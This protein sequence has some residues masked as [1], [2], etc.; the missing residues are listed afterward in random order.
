MNIP[1]RL[2]ELLASNDELHGSI[3][4]TLHDFQIWFEDRNLPFFPEYTDHGPKHIEEV[5]ATADG[6]VTDESWTLLT[7]EDAAVLI[8]SIVLHDCAMHLSED[9]FIAL[10]RPDTPRMLLEKDKPWPELWSDFLGEA[11]RFDSRKLRS[12]FGDTEPTHPPSLD[13]RNMSLRDRLLIGDFLRRHHPRLAHEIALWGVPGPSSDRIGLVRVPRGLDNLAGLSARSHGS[14]LRSSVE[15]LPPLSR[16]EYHKVHVPYLMAVLR[17]ADYIQIHSER[18]PKQVLKVRSLKSPFSQG[19]WNAHEAVED[20]HCTHEDPEAL[21]VVAKPQDVKTFLKLERLLEGLQAELDS[22]WAT[23]GEVYGRW[24]DLQRLGLTIRR[25]RS[26]LDDK[27]AFALTVPYYPDRVAFEADPEILKLLIDPLYGEDP[28]IGIRELLQNAVDACVDL[29]DYQAQLSTED[30]TIRSSSDPAVIIHLEET[31]DGGGWLTVTDSGIGMTAEVV[32]NYFLKAGA[33]FRRS[34]AWKELHETAEGKSRVL[35]SGRFGIGLLSAF[36]LGDKLNVSTRHVTAPEANG[37]QFCCSIEDEQ[38]EIMRAKLSAV[39]TSIRIRLA[40]DIFVKLYQ[41][42][43][44]WEW[45]H[46]ENPAVER[47]VTELDDGEVVGSI[48]P[49]TFSIPGAHE[50]LPKDW[51]RIRHRDFEDI[52]WTYEIRSRGY[53]DWN[54]DGILFCNGIEI[55]DLGSYRHENVSIVKWPLSLRKPLLSV[56]DPDGR[57]PLNLTR[58]TLTR[59]LP[60]EEELV[61][62]ICRDLIAKLLVTMPDSSVLDRRNRLSYEQISYPGAGA[63]PWGRQ[64]RDWFWLTHKGLSLATRFLL[65]EQRPETLYLIPNRTSFH[66]EVPPQGGLYISDLDST[67]GDFDPWLRFVLSGK[68]AG[69]WYT[70][71][72]WLNNL[73]SV[74]RRVLLNKK[75]RNRLTNPRIIP[76]GVWSTLVDEWHDKDWAILSTE[77]CPKATTDFKLLAS[78][79]KPDQFTA[80][81]EWYFESIPDDG[82]DLIVDRV[83]KELIDLPFIPFEDRRTVLANTFDKLTDHLASH[84]PVTKKKFKARVKK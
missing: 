28:A 79:L 11:S 70:T 44:E 16:R 8:L 36:L 58:S 65:S 1:K 81:A 63:R 9:G 77:D 22:S 84:Q 82:E 17:I 2:T 80:V 67:L 25:V 21:V 35:R 4:L 33:S 69:Y 37:I 57:L 26:N 68:V 40:R 55:G 41:E 10:M 34:E 51:H 14:S 73:P 13:A 53:R 46:L 75:Y 6:L 15:L 60:F 72:H 18:A 19:E 50:K 20:I 38:I 74:G 83:W 48:I 27:V 71:D 29:S 66:F 78:Q 56:F 5:M 39:G 32:K 49:A 59:Q 12:L 47:R 3:R 30:F 61:A 52:Q 76:K 24:G 7:P 62:D 45:Y 23:L 64:R 31:V 42:D 43:E 54:H